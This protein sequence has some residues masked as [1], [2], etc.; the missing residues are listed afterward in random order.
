MSITDSEKPMT[1]QLLPPP[2]RAHGAGWTDHKATDS[3]R[4][5][6]EVVTT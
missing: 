1:K 2:C 6:R 5:A 4:D 3:P